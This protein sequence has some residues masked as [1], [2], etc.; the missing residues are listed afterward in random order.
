MD[1]ALG[2]L[3]PVKRKLED[4]SINQPTQPTQSPPQDAPGTCAPAYKRRRSYRTAKLKE[5]FPDED[6]K[7]GNIIAL[8]GRKGSGKTTVIK[9]LCEYLSSVI[10]LVVVISP[11]AIGNKFHHF[12]PITCIHSQFDEH[13]LEALIDYQT[14]Q[15]EEEDNPKGK[16]VLLVFDDC[17]F[18]AAMFRC[19]AFRKLFFNC[20]WA[21][22]TTLIASQSPLNMPTYLR[23][24]IDITISACYRGER[25]QNQL[26]ENYF[27]VF[28]KFVDF[29][30]TMMKIARK[31]HMLVT[32]NSF[33]EENDVASNVYWYKA[34]YPV[35]D[36]KMGDPA[37]WEANDQRF[38]DNSKELEYAKKRKREIEQEIE[39]AKQPLY[40]IQKD[41]TRVH[42][43][44]NTLQARHRKRKT[45]FNASKHELAPRAMRRVYEKPPYSA[46]VARAYH[47]QP[48]IVAKRM[49]RKFS[50]N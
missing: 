31:R 27:S 1:K 42:I 17:A 34:R 47:A 9:D 11:T 41:L 3:K 32:V 22:I 35:P 10:D 43:P 38:M 46:A 39:D 44:A 45:M 36:F 6:I 13:Y 5:F 29:T 12:V 33:S 48:N 4:Q 40:E 16:E 19:E 14:K 26:Y 18:D 23:D 21:H 37:I 8:L 49:K 50:N 2:C 28:P 24:Q 20:R 30:R 7:L 25:A 15:W